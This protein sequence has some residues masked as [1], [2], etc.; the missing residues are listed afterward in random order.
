MIT[1]KT[2]V[3][4]ISQWPHIKNAEYELIEKLRRTD[5]YEFRVIDYLGND[6]ET[7]ERLDCTLLDFA[8]ALHY[9][10]PK[11]IDCPTYLAIINPIEFLT[12]RKD[13]AAQ[14][15]TNYLSHDHYAIAKSATVVRFHLNNLLGCD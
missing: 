4:I 5:G 13:Y 11:Y 9:D 2:R 10:T 6:V 15:A 1:R 14:P 7:N 8:I 12:M 3:G